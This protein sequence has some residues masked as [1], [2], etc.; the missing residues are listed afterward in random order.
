MTDELTDRWGERVADPFPDGAVPPAFR[1][2]RPQRRG[3]GRW[4]LAVL[5]LVVLAG[6]LVAAPWDAARR[7]AYAD[8]WVVWTDPPP[9]GISQLADQLALTETGRRIFFATRP[10]V[11]AARDFEEHCPFEAEVVLGCYDR[12]RIYVYDVTDERLAGTVEST[13]AHELLHAVY[14]RLDA[15]QADRID[16]LVAG[17]VATLPADDET[18]A[19]VDT[20]PEAQR[21]DEW[22]S[23]LGTSFTPLPAELDSTTRRSSWIAGSSSA[24]TA[25]RRRRSTATPTA[26]RS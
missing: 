8:Q 25:A 18:V 9:A 16:T 4:V 17:Y 22:H 24:T 15:T 10:Q 5:S 1:P 6:V 26:S 11:E 19:L 14:D 23:R 7:Q 12:G 2:R 21:A 13:T 3:V 20:Y